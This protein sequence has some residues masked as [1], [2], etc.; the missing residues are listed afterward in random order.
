MTLRRG[1]YFC[2]ATGKI[3]IFTRVRNYRDRVTDLTILNWREQAGFW[4]DVMI[5]KKQRQ[6]FYRLGDL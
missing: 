6:D 5:T 3:V 2:I 4:T 1:V